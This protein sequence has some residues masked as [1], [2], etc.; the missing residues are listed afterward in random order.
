MEKKPRLSPPKGKPAL[1]SLEGEEEEPSPEKPIPMSLA[2]PS[3]LALNNK[4]L[5][6]DKFLLMCNHKTAKW[7]QIKEILAAIADKGVPSDIEFSK[8]LV[9]IMDFTDQP[10]YSQ[11]ERLGAFSKYVGKLPETD[12][13]RIFAQ[14]IPFIA[15]LALQVELMYPDG[16]VPILS[17]RKQNVVK[18][19]RRE[20]S[21]LMA[22]MF[23]CTVPKQSKDFDLG[24]YRFYGLMCD[25]MTYCQYLID[26][27]LPCVLSYFAAIMEAEPEGVVTIARNCLTPEERKEF[28][29]ARWTASEKPL[30]DIT[31]EPK[32]RIEQAH[33]CL[34]V[35]FANHYIGG[36][37]DATCLQEQI[38][39]VIYPELFVTCLLCEKMED[40]E[41]IV[42]TGVEQYSNYTGYSESFKYAGKCADPMTTKR[43]ASGRIP[44]Q[45]VAI[46]ALCLPKPADRVKQFGE[47]YT[48]RELNKA[49][50]GFLG[51]VV[52]DPE[53]RRP[54]ATGKWGC[55]VFS[56]CNEYKFLI[57]WLAASEAGRKMVF[58]S[59]DEDVAAF[60]ETLQKLKSAK[61]GELARLTLELG[62]ELFK[63]VSA[64]PKMNYQHLT[65]ELLIKRLQG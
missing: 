59:F 25:D 53:D 65:H 35:D 38:L 14:L 28:T 10:F 34:Q 50:V 57:Q 4:I 62:R 46:D 43:D 56:G 41:A 22:N 8:C 26:E 27:K 20:V 30:V 60:V 24:E 11:K 29:L 64:N 5:P 9:R 42:I 16:T 55:G 39:F 36:G 37:V 47:E 6:Y 32:L 13:V 1:L 12:R 23:F 18:L 17:K 45:I 61:V 58:C 40:Y 31:L 51:D 33:D 44:R 3:E 7:S 15:G 49:Y 54:L 2:P 19:S 21:C 63:T 48:L 52:C